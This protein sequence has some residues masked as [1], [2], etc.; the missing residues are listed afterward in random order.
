MNEDWS[1][2]SIDNVL[3]C[4]KKFKVTHNFINDDILVLFVQNK[5]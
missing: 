4:F 5:S 3:N 1:D 2:I